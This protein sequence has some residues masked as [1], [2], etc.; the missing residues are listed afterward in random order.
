MFEKVSKA[1]IRPSTPGR[2]SSGQAMWDKG[3]GRHWLPLVV[4][5]A[6]TEYSTTG[7]PIC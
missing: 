2:R 6:P 4:D 7:C 1:H 3:Q 5:M